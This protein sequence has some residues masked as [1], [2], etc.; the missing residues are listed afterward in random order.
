MKNYRNWYLNSVRNQI[1]TLFF[2]LGA[3]VFGITFYLTHFY[4]LNLLEKNIELDLNRETIRSGELIENIL[5]GQA[6]LI[7]QIEKKIRTVYQN[8]KK[9]DPSEI[10]SLFNQ[11][12]ALNQN[13]QIL[14]IQNQNNKNI[15]E[16]GPSSKVNTK[17]IESISDE[18]KR[19]KTNLIKFDDSLAS[20]WIAFPLL[21]DRNALVEYVVLMSVPLEDLTSMALQGYNNLDSF[22][23]LKLGDQALLQSH[24]ILPSI[25]WRTIEHHLS[26]PHPFNNIDLKI[27]RNEY[28]NWTKQISQELF[29]PFLIIFIISLSTLIVLA[30]LAGSFIAKPIESLCDQLNQAEFQKFSIQKQLSERPDEIGNLQRA[31]DST[32]HKVNTN[33]ELLESNI[34]E[35][36]I[37]LSTIFDVSP[38]C[39]IA[40]SKNHVVKNVNQSFSR[41]SDIYPNDVMGKDI[42]HL[43]TIFK[44]K[45][46]FDD[47]SQKFYS[48]KQESEFLN[49][50]SAVV[51]EGFFNLMKRENTN[52]VFSLKPPYG[53]TLVSQVRFTQNGDKIIFLH[54][55][56]N[57]KEFFAMRAN[58]LST[59]AHELRTPLSSI[60]GYIDILNNKIKNNIFDNRLT[61]EVAEVIQ[62][63]SRYMAKLISDLLDLSR[64]DLAGKKN[65]HKV[66]VSLNDSIHLVIDQSDELDRSRLNL[67][68]QV[69]LPNVIIDFESFKRVLLN[70]LDN[71]FKYSSQDSPVEVNTF[72]KIEDDVQFVAI[73]IVDYGIGIS[74][75]D[76]ARLFNR[77]VRGSNVSKIKGTGL[78]LCIAQ[79]I[80][81]AHAGRINVQSELNKG[82]RMTLLFPL[83]VSA[84]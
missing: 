61:I 39:F 53:K 48:V 6:V 13:R 8:N 52:Y 73:E 42:D 9:I 35:N 37:L 74:T 30:R 70:L 44:H 58:F 40:I 7:N 72:L 46:D 55:V 1:S 16:E 60:L 79:E 50:E 5:S 54:D 47:P 51:K 31:L 26:V 12:N 32:M 76:Q 18:V 3:V 17:F 75:I 28:K 77:F 62:R 38:D 34:A 78:G 24:Q 83:V 20:L 19:K 63:Q 36:E 29:L 23:F 45:V 11:P 82:T 21:S 67:N 71:A 15:V 81:N 84:D 2:F 69:D 41:V 4:A 57:E 22:L 66:L 65:I 80:M 59:A 49:D 43:N 27:S 10:T 56:T 33:I 64:Y 14:I 68:L 25:A